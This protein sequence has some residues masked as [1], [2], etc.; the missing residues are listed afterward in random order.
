VKYE[1]T[2]AFGFACSAAAIARVIP[3]T[4]VTSAD[5]SWKTRTS[6]GWSPFPKVFTIC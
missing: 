4:V 6:G 3:G 1:L 5:G 2:R